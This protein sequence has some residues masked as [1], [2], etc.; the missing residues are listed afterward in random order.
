MRR[1]SRTWSRQATT[2]QTTT[3]LHSRGQANRHFNRYV[4][5]MGVVRYAI[6]CL[7]AGAAMCSSAGVAAAADGSVTTTASYSA[8]TLQ[9]PADASS[10]EELSPVTVTWTGALQGASGTHDQSFF[11]A[12]LAT[13]SSVPSG[14]NA[15]WTNVANTVQTVA[16][17]SATSITI[18]APSA[19]SYKWRVCA[20]GVRDSN[21]SF[22]VEQLACSPARSVTVTA[23]AV[24]SS[25]GV[26]T[27][28]RTTTT[29]AAPTI[30]H[31]TRPAGHSKPNI[32][33]RTVVR[34]HPSTF[35]VDKVPAA[36]AGALSSDSV[37]QL[38]KLH[39]TRVSSPSGAGTQAIGALGGGIAAGA[40]WTVPGLSLPLWLFLIVLLPIPM[41]LIWR[42][43]ALATFAASPNDASSTISSPLIKRLLG[44][45]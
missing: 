1:R 26:V 23:A 39:A 5:V 11:V 28:D 10:S 6:C 42:R 27:I 40:N 20:W 43:S 4:H 35:V 29:T 37:V 7:V 16:G 19:G 30:K 45:S 44:L 31:V 21:A 2:T 8:P 33:K 24:T 41:A 3:E 12:Q 34:H 38:D 13:S 32:V 36:T 22:A 25:S 18:G 15:A 9:Q 17:E 14:Q